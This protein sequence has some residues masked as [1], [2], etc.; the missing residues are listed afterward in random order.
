MKHLQ[1]SRVSFNKYSVRDKENE[2]TDKIILYSNFFYLIYL[3]V[4]KY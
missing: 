2:T 1:Q 4:N 3:D